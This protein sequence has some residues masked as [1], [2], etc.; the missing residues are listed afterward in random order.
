MALTA[1]LFFR[2]MMAL[3]AI[4]ETAARASTDKSRK[5]EDLQPSQ[6]MCML[7]VR[8]NQSNFKDQINEPNFLWKKTLDNIRVLLFV[9]SHLPD[10]H[11]EFLRKCWPGLI[12][13]SSLLQHADVLF[14]AGGELPTDILE[15]VFQGKNVRVERYKNPGY[16][17]GAMLAMEAATSQHWFDDYDWVIRVNPDVLILDDEW[18]VKN[19]LD[20]GVDGIFADCHDTGCTSQCTQ[21][22]WV[23]TDFY[24][25]R[26]DQLDP[27]SFVNAKGFIDA[28]EQATM[29]FQQIIQAGR[30]RWVP[31]TDMMGGCRIRGKGVPVIHAHS[32]L[33]QCPLAKGWQPA[34]S[35]LW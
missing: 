17:E 6:A 24:A 5:E 12:S 7:T 9:T 15:D 28:E 31:G 11:V 21:G 8:Q 23:N 13:K 27:A 10:Q 4:D 30:D 25:V 33:S 32:V 29:A 34:D 18:L 16:Q 19:L 26:T 2:F 3:A 22:V 35:D 20:D 14:F 1:L